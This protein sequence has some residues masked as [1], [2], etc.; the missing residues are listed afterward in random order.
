MRCV[1]PHS[2]VQ[3]SYST[4][5]GLHI[6]V[7]IIYTQTQKLQSTYCRTH[8]YMLLLVQTLTCNLNGQQVT[9]AIVVSFIPFSLFRMLCLQ[10]KRIMWHCTQV[11]KKRSY[12]HHQGELCKTVIDVSRQMIVVVKVQSVLLFVYSMYSEYLIPFVFTY[13]IRFRSAFPASLISLK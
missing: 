10:H 7:H 3:G 12:L 9:N 4:K 13:V 2:V 8:I 11:K 1:L 5:N 6:I